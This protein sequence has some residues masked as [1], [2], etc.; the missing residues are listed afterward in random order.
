MT[1]PRDSE[2]TVVRRQAQPYV[3]IRESVPM[4]ELGR[5]AHRIPEVIGWLGS[6]GL[7][8]AG[9]PFF[10]Y[11][12]IDMARTLEVEVGTAV[13]SAV[14]G[15]GAVVDGTLPAGRYATLTHIGSP[16]DLE[17]ATARLLE[18]GAA[19]G[20][21]WDMTETDAGEVWGCR[22]E[23]YKTDPAAEPD[24]SRWQTELAFRLAD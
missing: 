6:R 3:A 19:Q 21:R 7:A 9:P 4:R 12:V 15:E 24:M 14:P 11:D 13:L 1:A 5:V 20:L 8:A 23:L 2:P 16:D 18:W 22:L 17:Q 10:K